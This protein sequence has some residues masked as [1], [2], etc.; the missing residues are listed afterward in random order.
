[1]PEEVRKLYI[2]YFRAYFC[3]AYYFIKL[4]RRMDSEKFAT[5]AE[6]GRLIGYI[7]LYGKIYWI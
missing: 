6:K 3:N 2:Y 1:M 7:D 5:R 4:Y